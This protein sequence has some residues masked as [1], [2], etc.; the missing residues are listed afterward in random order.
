MGRTYLALGLAQSFSGG[1]QR[2]ADTAK[3]RAGRTVVAR[4]VRVKEGGM[5]ERVVT[6][7]GRAVTADASLSVPK[8]VSWV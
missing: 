2:P 7:A 4:R 6:A 5:L 8:G 1:E 3:C